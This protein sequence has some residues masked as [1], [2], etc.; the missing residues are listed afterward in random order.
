[1]D[2]A[3]VSAEF[4][5]FDVGAELSTGTWLLSVS[6]SATELW[7]FLI[8]FC[9]PFFNFSFLCN[10]LSFS[11]STDEDTGLQIESFCNSKK[12]GISKKQNLYYTIMQKC[13][14]L[15]NWLLF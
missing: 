7:D 2:D 8:F 1:M 11:F 5:T 13:K 12:H 15:I 3:G 4:L 10:L 9:N 6:P 14:E